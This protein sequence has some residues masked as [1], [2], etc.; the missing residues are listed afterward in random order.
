MLAET[1]FTLC[2]RTHVGSHTQV[3]D[4]Q[5]IKWYEI[6][7]TAVVPCECGADMLENDARLSTDHN[8]GFSTS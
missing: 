2:I 6:K 5:M 8:N 3:L 4:D 1:N 7:F